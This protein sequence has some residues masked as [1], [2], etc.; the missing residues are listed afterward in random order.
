M[1]K[2]ENDTISLN[3]G[4]VPPETTTQT[5]ETINE[6]ITTDKEMKKIE[7]SSL[8]KTTNK[9]VSKSL[10]IEKAADGELTELATPPRPGNINIL[11]FLNPFVNRLLPLITTVKRGREKLPCT[12]TGLILRC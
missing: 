1:L 2:N 3:E 11:S 6:T 4:E 10:I 7:L 8:E 5:N 12:I 9:D